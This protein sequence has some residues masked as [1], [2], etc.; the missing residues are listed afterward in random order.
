MNRGDYMKKNI[1][2]FTLIE[3]IVVI[4]IIGILAAIMAPALLG[5]VAQSKIG[6]SN[7]NAK[8]LYT[9]AN[10]VATAYDNE[11]TLVNGTI[12]NNAGTG[13]AVASYDL[14]NS[15]GKAYHLDLQIES[16]FQAKGWTWAV[17][18]CDNRVVS[19]VVADPSNIYVGGYPIP[20]PT[21]KEYKQLSGGNIC[22][23]LKCAIDSGTLYDASGAATDSPTAWVATS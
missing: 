20:C 11:G 2:G 10:V 3:L 14:C 4:S 15:A 18:I 23:Y 8:L 22:D 5:Y 7:A 19:V 12:Y 21:E 9:H 16:G 17:N 1:K 6:K 13:I